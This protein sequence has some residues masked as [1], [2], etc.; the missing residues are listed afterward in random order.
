[1]SPITIARYAIRFA[2]WVMPHAQRFAHDYGANAR[3]AER[4]FDRGNYREAAQ[5]YAA[6]L[7]DANSRRYPARKKL[8]ILLR[9]AESLRLSGELDTALATA[10]EAWTRASAMGEADPFHGAALES[11]SL[12]YE[13]R[14]ED[15]DA[16]LFARK[17]LAAA[18][19]GASLPNCA[20]RA[21]RLAKLELEA[22]NVEK[23]KQLL[24]ASIDYSHRAH[25]PD[26]PGTATQLASMALML[27]E[28]GQ[29]TEAL[30]I[31]QK[32]HAVHKRLLGDTA[33]ETM[34]DL[35]HI[36]QIHYLQKNLDEA[37]ASYRRL[38]IH[39]ENEIGGKP[40]EHARFLIDA[41]TVHEAAGQYGKALEFLMQANQ[42]ASRDAELAPIVVERLARVRQY[43]G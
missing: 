3:E 25:G 12:I 40:N 14:E 30:P 37:L 18:E 36:G 42:K 10:K 38:A 29:L 28:E 24:T 5:Y 33:P 1:M 13:A 19:K 34:R 6:N 31:F 8:Q 7:K 16:L 32:A 21:G 43:V 11:L 22:G 2:Q 23:A 41:A 39:K 17:A 20:T 15:V 4:Y 27:Q 35:E 26:H 9:L